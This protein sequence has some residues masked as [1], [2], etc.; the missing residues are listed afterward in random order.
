MTSRTVA[1]LHFGCSCIVTW[2]F[3]AFYAAGLAG[4]LAYKPSVYWIVPCQYAPSVLAIVF[5]AMTEGRAGLSRLRSDVFRWCGKWIAIGV[6]IPAGIYSLATLVSILVLGL[7]VDWSRIG[8]LPALNAEF[9]RAQGAGAVGDFMASSYAIYV[10]LFVV[11]AIFNGGVSEELGWRG[12]SQPK[13][14]SRHS[15]LVSGLLVGVMWSL[16]HLGPPQWQELFTHGFGAFAQAT[17]AQWA[18]YLLFVVP[19]AVVFAWLYNQGRGALLPCIFMHAASN[20]SLILTSLICDSDKPIFVALGLYVAFVIG[21]VWK[22]G[23]K[24]LGAEPRIV[25]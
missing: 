22:F 19:E 9:L 21:L 10:V 16:W 13:L 24:D 15:A 6:C 7:K 11:L 12:L 1:W 4:V 5:Y 25:R 17:L 23:A 2:A 18:Q 8:R 3:M 20:S 14:Q